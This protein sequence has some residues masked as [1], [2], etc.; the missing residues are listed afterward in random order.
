VLPVKGKIVPVG[1][2]IATLNRTQKDRD[3]HKKSGHLPAR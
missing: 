1:Q 2:C 3:G